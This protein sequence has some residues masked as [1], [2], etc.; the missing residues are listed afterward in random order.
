MEQGP[1]R[2]GMHKA[3]QIAPL[4][5][6][7]HWRER[8]LPLRCPNATQDGFEPNAMFVGSPQLDLRLGKRRRHLLDQRPQLFLNASCAAGSAWTCR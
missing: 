6:V 2:G 5:A 8:T 1:A 3:H 4:V 7:L